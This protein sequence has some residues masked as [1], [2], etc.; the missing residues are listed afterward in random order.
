MLAP[1]S[2]L[3]FD[4][5]DCQSLD[6]ISLHERIQEQDRPC[7][8]NGHRH[9]RRFRRHFARHDDTGACPHLRDE[10]HRVDHV[11]QIILQ[12]IL[13]RIIDEQRGHEPAVPI[14][15]RQEQADGCDAGHRQLQHDAV[16]NFEIVG[17]VNLGGLDEFFG[18]GGFH[19]AAHQND[20]K[21]AHQ[22]RQHKHRISVRQLQI[23]GQKN[24]PRDQAAAEQRSEI[25]IE[26]ELIAVA[27]IFALQHVARH[28]HEEQAER[29]SDNRDQNRYAVCLKYLFREAEHRFIAFNRK[30]LG[31][32]VIAASKNRLVLREGR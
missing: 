1:S 10:A 22:S 24:I 25:N 29:R 32:E 11:V 27:K 31:E 13:V 9:L 6:E 4:S 19:E 7:D 28:R 30:H 15:Q 16:V 17:T 14:M 5:T 18:N 21:R 3:T 2:V 8:D 26:R 12:L 23:A 20:E